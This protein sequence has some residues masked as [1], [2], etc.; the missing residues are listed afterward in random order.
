MVEVLTAS[1][2]AHLVCVELNAMSIAITPAKYVD[3]TVSSVGGSHLDIT[4]VW[5]VGRLCI[6]SNQHLASFSHKALLTYASLS[7]R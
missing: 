1:N 2:V 7:L 4:F 6:D 3:F 5:H